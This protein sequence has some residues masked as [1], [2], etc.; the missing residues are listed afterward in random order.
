M[1]DM[2][3]PA[4]VIILLAKLYGKQQARVKVAGTI[5]RV[6]SQERGETGVCNIT[7]FI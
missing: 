5:K 2:G 3:Y 1:T 7:L 4:H 6:Q